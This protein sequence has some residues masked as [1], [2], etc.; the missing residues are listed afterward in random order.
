M[1]GARGSARRQLVSRLLRP[2]NRHRSAGGAGVVERLRPLARPL[3][4]IGAA[5]VLGLVVVP[6]VV[7]A[8]RR[9]P[10][11]VADRIELQHRGRL[12]ADVLRA[13]LGLAERQSIWDV[14]VEALEARV[15]AVPWVRTATVRRVLPDRL[16]VRVREHRPVAILAVTDPAPGLYYLAA[17][18]R[19]FAGVGDDDGRDLPYVTG[20]GRGDLD[21]RENFGP[22]AIHRALGLLRLVARDAPGLGPVSEIHVDRDGGLTLL[23]T[24]PAIPIALGTAPYVAKLTRV[25]R[26]LP[27]WTGREAEVA[28]IS[29][30]DNQV[31]VRTRTPRAGTPGRAASGA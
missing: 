3:A 18:G 31:I 15:R 17:N 10:Y 23:P 1:A 2:R 9:H 4:Q 11:F 7:G 30:F 12:P 28:G 25:G 24:R 13:A 16:V 6:A 19:I 29:V 26:V 27:L 20:L 14:D 21:G 5:L 22:Q 8:A